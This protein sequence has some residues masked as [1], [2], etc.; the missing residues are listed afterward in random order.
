MT[1][2]LNKEQDKPGHQAGQGNAQNGKLRVPKILRVDS[3]DQGCNGQ[4][5]T[6]GK[7]QGNFEKDIE[8]QP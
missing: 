6:S 8:W 2:V 5:K 3:E 7:G 1:C 4:R